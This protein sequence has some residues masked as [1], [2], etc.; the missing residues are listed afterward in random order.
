M[1]VF[2]ALLP[3]KHLLVSFRGTDLPERWANLL[4]LVSWFDFLSNAASDITLGAIPLDW[5][6]ADRHPIPKVRTPKSC[7]SPCKVSSLSFVHKGGGGNCCSS[8]TPVCAAC[9]LQAAVVSSTETLQMQC[10]KAS[11]LTQGLTAAF[12]CWLQRLKAMAVHAHR[13]TKASRTASMTWWRARGKLQE[14]IA[15]LKAATGL[16]ADSAWP[17]ISTCK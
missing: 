1:Q 13:C 16:P 6:P 11:N 17:N 10:R 3:G 12:L 5:W 7:S 8:A 14:A 9:T 4:N 15:S 2:V